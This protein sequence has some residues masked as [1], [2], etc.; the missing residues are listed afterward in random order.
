[1][2]KYVHQD[3]LCVHSSV[4][5]RQSSL[6]GITGSLFGAHACDPVIDLVMT[7]HVQRRLLSRTYLLISLFI[8]LHCARL[9]WHPTTKAIQEI[10]KPKCSKCEQEWLDNK[11]NEATGVRAYVHCYI[12]S[13]FTWTFQAT[14]WRQ[15][16][17]L[18]YWARITQLTWRDI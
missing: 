10:C 13:P 14:C 6:F 7:S 2:V 1:M 16:E 8:F 18:K 3:S 11:P 15:D 17:G 12:S 4:R 5:M 9:T